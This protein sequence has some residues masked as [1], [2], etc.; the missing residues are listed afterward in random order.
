MTANCPWWF[1]VR[2]LNKAATPELDE[3]QDGVLYKGCGGPMPCA[4]TGDWIMS[5]LPQPNTTTCTHGVQE[6][7]LLFHC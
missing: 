2:L 3:C 6:P 7:P 1:F 4:R 5:E